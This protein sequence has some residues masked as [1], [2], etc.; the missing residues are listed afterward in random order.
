MTTAVIA[1]GLCAS[2]ASAQAPR[3]PEQK[4]NA[5]Y[6]Q[7]PW[8]VGSNYTPK[9]AINQLEMW[10][11]PPSSRRNRPG[12]DLGRISGMNTCASSCTIYSGSRMPQLSEAHR[13][14]PV[15]RLAPY[16]VRC[17][18]LFDSCWDPL[19]ISARSIRRFR[20]YT[21]PAGCR[22]P[23]PCASG[24][25][26]SSAPESLHPRRRGSPRKTIASS[27][28]TFGMSPVPTTLAATRSRS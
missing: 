26:S 15:D 4:A 19:L 14:L 23:A 28:G 12:I 21:T 17:L 25:H 16:I 24:P 6:T 1:V 20:A 7:Q 9:S 22:A 11:E 13:S 8:L 3:W 18:W 2:A 5:W 27:H 10:Q